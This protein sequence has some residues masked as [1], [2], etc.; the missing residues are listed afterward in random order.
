VQHGRGAETP[1]ARAERLCD[2]ARERFEK[3]TNDATLAWQWGRACF[4]A[5]EFAPNDRRREEFALQG[6]RA[7]EVAVAVDPR[8]APAHY[9]LALNQGQ[10]AR[11]RLLGAL[12]LVN[13]ME[14]A[15]KKSI[16]LDPKF[17]FAGTHRTLGTLYL[18]APSWPA[19]IGSKSKAREHLQKAVDL[20]P[21][22]PGN[23]LRWLE[24]LMKW[25]EKR[26]VREALPET[27]KVLGAARKQLT[28]EA[29][30]TSWKEWDERLARIKAGVSG[31]AEAPMDRR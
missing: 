26:K 20:V 15:L 25:G 24:A 10:L 12:K 27:E 6:I 8:T 31:S 18:D 29:W 2:E 13:E 1:R 3:K 30:E 11:T 28:G 14:V 5:A 21:D 7:C 19:S 23:R 4:D 17:D 9:Y 22:Y 16:E